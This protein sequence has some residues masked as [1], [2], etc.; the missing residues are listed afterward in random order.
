MPASASSGMTH[1]VM[2]KHR[3]TPGNAGDEGRRTPIFLSLSLF[4][5]MIGESLK[6]AA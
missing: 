2:N 4:E 1:N 3:K 5:S 6:A